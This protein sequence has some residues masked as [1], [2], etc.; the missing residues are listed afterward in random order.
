MRA[1]AATR[2]AQ[3]PLSQEDIRPVALQP[4]ERPP[5][6]E[7]K[8]RYSKYRSEYIG[9]M[10]AFFGVEPVVATKTSERGTEVILVPPPFPTMEAFA[11]RI[12]VTTKVLYAWRAKHPEFEEATARARGCQ[13]ALLQECGLAGHYSPSTVI[14]GL[15][16][17]ASWRHKI[18]EKAPNSAVNTAALDATFAERMKRSAETTR[19]LRHERASLLGKEPMAPM[20]A[21]R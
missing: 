21:H 19:R 5:A 9:M 4:G 3:P 11:K 10:D 2:G 12:G 1:E 6:Y 16:N 13:V 20:E 18:A 14:L 15:R 7:G 8:G 17:L